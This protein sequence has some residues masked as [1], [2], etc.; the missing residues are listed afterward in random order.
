MAKPVGETPETSARWS[1]GVDGPR[2][3]VTL[4]INGLREVAALC[5]D[6]KPVLEGVIAELNGRLSILNQEAL[7][8]RG[9][10]VAPSAELQGGLSPG[11]QALLAKV[12]ALNA[13]LKPLEEAQ[14]IGLRDLPQREKEVDRLA[15]EFKTAPEKRK[16]E[17]SQKLSEARRGLSALKRG[18]E[19]CARVLEERTQTIADLRAKA[20]AP[21][22]QP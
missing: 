10:S 8:G 11:R 5:A 4:D 13:T 19:V 16:D 1:T 14:K 17:I 20:A 2:N 12:A 22:W 9:A 18:L 7:V 21:T 15:Q 6:S 3:E